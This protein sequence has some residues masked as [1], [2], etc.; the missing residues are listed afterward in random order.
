MNMLTMPSPKSKSPNTTSS[1]LA[2]LLALAVA[3]CTAST[4]RAQSPDINKSVWKMLYGVTEAQITSLTWPNL[5][6]DGDGVKNG[7]EIATGTNPFLAN[8]T[9]RVADLTANTT[10]VSLTFPT[11]N[12]KKYLVQ[13]TPSLS[14]TTWQI[15]AG[16]EVIGDGTSKMLTAPKSA[17]SFFRVFVQDLDTDSDGVSDWVEQLVGYNPSLAAT[18]GVLGDQTAI[19]S[20]LASQNI[21]TLVAT[22]PATAQPATNVIPTVGLA[23]INVNRGNNLLFGAVTVPLVKSGS[24]VE[25][26]DYQALPASVSFPANVRTVTVY[27][28]PLYN[29]ARTTSATLTLTAQAG[30]GYTVGTPNSA[31]VTI[32]ASG[33]PVGT[34]LTGNYFSTAN[35]TTYANSANVGSVT[36]SYTYIQNS[37]TSGTAVINYTPATPTT[38][39]V[40]GQPVHV[41]YTSGPLLENVPIFI[42][43]A[44]KWDKS[45]TVTVVNT[46]AKSVTVEIAGASVPA[47][48]SGNCFIGP[49]TAPTLTRLDPVV[50]FTWNTGS[51]S[52]TSLPTAGND[53]WAARFEGWLNPPTTG[54]YNFDVLA[55]DGARV[56][57]DTNANGTIEPG[58]LVIDA[59]APGIAAFAPLVT[60]SP[61][62]LIAGTRVRMAVEY[63]ELNGN[64]ALTLRWKKP[65][66]SGFVGIPSGT[67]FLDP[68]T[69]A[70]GWNGL[71]WTNTLSTGLPRFGDFVATLNFTN[72]WRINGA[73]ADQGQ[74]QQTLP[75][76]DNFSASWDGYYSP[77]STGS[78]VFDVQASD[79]AR[80]YLDINLNGTFDLTDKII[81]AWT[82]VDTAAVTP[83]ASGANSLTLGQKYKMR[84]EYSEGTGTA[85]VK[86]RA[87]VD[88][89]AFAAINA[90]ANVFRPDPVTGAATT[91][92]GW[93]SKFYS[94]AT[95][96]EPPLYAVQETS[97]TSITNDTVSNW[98]AARP[99]PSN[100]GT[101]GSDNWAARFDG[102]VKATGTAGNYF[103]QLVADDQARLFVNNV[104][105]IPWSSGTVSHVTG[106]N[107]TANQV[108]P[109]RVE[110]NEFTGNASVALN[111]KTPAATTSFV[112]VP[113]TSFFQDAGG[114]TAGLAFSSWTNTGMLGL[115][116]F[117]EFR[118][119]V[120]YNVGGGQPSQTLAA[121]DNFS[122]QWDGYLRPTTTDSYTFDIQA[123]DGAE[124]YLDTN[125]NGTFDPSD[126]IVD[127]WTAGSST[128]T[129]MVSAAY[130]LTAGQ[131]YKFQV[132]YFDGTG[133]AVVK[134]RWARA[135]QAMVGIANTNLYRDLTT[136]QL[137]LLA[138][139]Y[140]N[141]TLTPPFAYTVAENNNPAITYDLSIGRPDPVLPKDSFSVRWA[142]QVLPQ[143][144]ETYFFVARND[145]GVKLWVNNQ[146]IATRWPGGGTTDTIGSI[147]LQAGVR[148][149]IVLDYYEG[150]GGAE[151]HLQW[152]SDSQPKQVIPT[153]RLFPTPTGVAP[154]GGNPIASAPSITSPTSAVALVNGGAF[155][156]TI[157]ASNGG[158]NFTVSG[159]P[160]WLTLSNG[161]ISGTPPVG[162]AG[163]YQFTISATNAAGTTN[164]V[165]DLDVIDAGGKY[166]RDLW[167]SVSSFASFATSSPTSS[168][169]V[170]VAN[171]ED[172]TA[173]GD[174]TGQRL[175]GY[176]IPPST[177]NYYFWLSANNAAQLWISN[178]AEPVNK[179]LRSTVAAPGSAA[180]V[181]DSQTSQKSPWLALIGGR[182]YYYEILHISPAGSATDNVA[183]GYFKDTTGN[184]A[185]IANGTS[186]VPN[187]MLAPFDNPVTT[188]VSGKIYIT[189]LTP[190]AGVTTN[191]IGGAYVR[192]N[193]GETQ[194]ILHF[195]YSGLTSGAIEDT[196]G[197][198]L[199]P[200]NTLLV[201]V[202][203]LEKYYSGNPNFITADGGYVWNM[204]AQNVADLKNGKI[205]FKVATTNN[206]TGELVGTLGYVP[207]SQTAPAVPSVPAWSDDSNTTG[208]GSRFFSQ[209]TYGPKPADITA[210]AL[211]AQTGSVNPSRF[212]TWIDSQ[213][214]LTFDNALNS[215]TNTHLVP[216]VLA[217]LSANPMF[218]YT[219]ATVFNSWWKNS[220]TA[221]H[222]LRHRVAF[223]LSEILVVSNRGPLEDNGRILA[224]FY[225]VLLDNSFGNFRDLLEA[226][227]LTPAMGIYLDMRGNDKGDIAVGRSPNENY[228]REILQLFSVGLYR[229]WPDGSLVL[230]SKGDPVPTYDQEVIK[231]F[232]RVFT[233]WN[234]GQILLSGNRLPTNFGPAANFLDPMI[235]VP[236]RH[237]LGSKLLLDNVV[238]P[239]ATITSSSDPG[240][241]PTSTY[242]VKSPVDPIGQPGVLTTTTITNLYD[243]N[244]LKDFKVSHDQIANHPAVGP[245][246]CRQLIQRLVTSHPTPEYLHRVVRAFNGERNVDGIATGVRGDLKDV[247][248]AIL[249]DY[250]AR[251]TTAAAIATYGKQREPLLRVT[252]PARA[253]PPITLSGGY[254]QNE[255][256]DLPTNTKNSDSSMVATITAT[257]H[258][259]T[260]GDTVFLNFSSPTVGPV[261]TKGAYVARNVNPNTFT[262]NLPGLPT[263]ADPSTGIA[264][265]QT[266]TSIIVTANNVALGQKVYLK[267][268]KNG[269]ATANNTNSVP[270]NAASDLPP[271]GIYTA[272]AATGS[273]F[274]V[275]TVT[276]GANNTAA[277]PRTNAS[278]RL[279]MPRF[280]GGNGAAGY[281]VRSN[282]G[283]PAPNDKLIT[284]ATSS[285]HELSTGQQ[286]Y[287]DFPPN[288]NQTNPATTVPAPTDGVYTIAYLDE[289]HFTVTGTGPADA[290]QPN[291]VVYPLVKPVLTRTGSVAVEQSTFNMGS[292]EP[293]LTQ[294][295]LNS[296]TVFNFFYPDYQF[297]G[298]LA[299][300]G[301]TTPEFQLTTDTNVMNLQNFI[302][303]GIFLALNPNGFTGFKNGGGAIVMDFNAYMTSGQTSD[304]GLPALVDTLST[305]LMGQTLST[306]KRDAIVNYVKSKPITAIGT[307]AT[308]L[309]TANNHGFAN[310]DTINISGVGGGSFT[311]VGI[312]A[313][314]VVTY[315]NTNQFRIP[316]TCNNTTGL[317][318][319]DARAGYLPFTLPT[320]TT[321]QMRDRVR[322]VVYF[323]ISSPDYAI[324]K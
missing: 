150:S 244:G 291:L 200:S 237:E 308:C 154:S 161:V 95:L 120:N 27:V 256:S 238:L 114:F 113:T 15:V 218:P 273:T 229:L 58:E 94:N 52:T 66:D 134:L 245:L 283:V 222:Q 35:G 39:F 6:D 127:A 67:V 121:V 278:N 303:N 269:A 205:F 25:G 254:V 148:Y 322:A 123:D 182:K 233:G 48:G 165:V 201:K 43:T 232:A 251:S 215:P 129:P 178:D 155:S 91:T 109:I 1:G 34:G 252:G 246:V 265:T 33:N 208:G 99:G 258:R 316:I 80:V 228:A 313:N 199:S 57:V 170:T 253:F 81:D 274:T 272:T 90:G 149:D 268:V 13:A 60:S 102:F 315:V 298:P 88:A 194:G 266:G 93:W 159:L 79:G 295:P 133:A 11:S 157:A 3:F 19:N 10:T 197:L 21:V 202:S 318:L 180:Q 190:S 103:F 29:P 309:I 16:V 217:N 151:S 137:G 83:A 294:S 2:L 275:S 287:L 285:N 18:N 321:G 4:A 147:A 119:Q 139:Y 235:L 86:L 152:Y 49:F 77:P 166:T 304:A 214:T 64:A 69:S 85:L 76:T 187:A 75:N 224:D 7:D 203:D 30:G 47:T 130:P 173:Y 42:G 259:L 301:L 115:P 176:I 163:H 305:L 41:S 78:W 216:D 12:L 164:T 171:L 317:V 184:S 226:V 186:T 9:L 71:Y 289:D 209:S 267:F 312:N 92:T 248:R 225:D 306:T 142:G 116:S 28:T 135:G 50:D 189:E 72:N 56:Y 106:V 112:L 302:Y 44:N 280:G 65:S 195:D 241:D 213:F 104:E 54:A 220:I 45:Y 63:Y 125:Q 158:G 242:T 31:S 250:E 140:S 311:G 53:N 174:S 299:T 314:H 70:I 260:N 323:L 296:P 128:T 292:T 320:P 98:T 198:Y 210:L 211:L 126:K 270:S 141:A 84:V 110:F 40:V 181:W 288:T 107:L 160:A 249:L 324:Q 46:I 263:I 300:A 73:G 257:S 22:E 100:L 307:G 146:L 261:I 118:T 20:N 24:A 219:A 240:T 8:S 169:D 212:R 36:A 62:N 145:E 183:L 188:A 136:S 297:P 59:W 111:W 230:D 179:V 286:V 143:Y 172:N 162:S 290:D 51:P 96:A 262:V 221:N 23:A 168:T 175:R 97:S 236:T 281:S 310:G 14:P 26:V 32:Y 144:S 117:S 177:G 231:G 68:A 138:T 108:V 293:E 192:V 191:A 5:D 204:S 185:A 55:D 279:V 247:I 89:G 132:R 276:E 284:V 61:I 131:R 207:G 105:V 82:P 153:S 38:P 87:K 243:L 319:M 156:Y 223:A 124:V 234:Y 277:S 206:P 101:S 74:P 122:A 37:A 167:S 227:T 17:G 193:T 282:T 271:D 239:P 264:W 196:K 255:F